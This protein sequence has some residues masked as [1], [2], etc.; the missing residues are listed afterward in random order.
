MSKLNLKNNVQLV[1]KKMARHLKVVVMKDGNSYKEFKVPYCTDEFNTL[2]MS[3]FR[4]ALDNAGLSYITTADALKLL[5][6]V[7]SETV[8]GNSPHWYLDQQISWW[9]ELINEEDWEG[10]WDLDPTEVL[11]DYGA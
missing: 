3:M 7:V 1:C 5:H 2:E 6:Y 8:C 10:P 4:H 9:E 11:E